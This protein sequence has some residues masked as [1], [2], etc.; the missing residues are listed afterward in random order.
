MSRGLLQASIVCGRVI[1]FWIEFIFIMNDKGVRYTVWINDV[2]LAL[3]SLIHMIFVVQALN[4]FNN[5]FFFISFWA[6]YAFEFTWNV[7]KW[8]FL[9]FQKK[10]F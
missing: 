8:W 10:A 5:N 1:I 9:N 7:A 2:I 4:S 6:D 3:N